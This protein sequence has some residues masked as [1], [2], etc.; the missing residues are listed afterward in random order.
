MSEEERTPALSI[1]AA[2]PALT[3]GP[4]GPAVMAGARQYEMIAKARELAELLAESE[5][6][7]E[8]AAAEEAMLGDPEAGR[9]LQAAEEAKGY[10]HFTAKT[11]DKALM[12]RAM[13]DFYKAE[14]MQRDYPP[15]HRYNE[16]KDRLQYLLDRLNAIITYPITGSDAVKS[17]GGG[18]GSGGSC[19][20][21]GT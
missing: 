14:A 3:A 11:Q 9:L 16:A 18:C 4:V 20:G 10:T 6:V 7:R 19:G 15:I 17:G 1:D 13:D 5:E 8:F 21:C 12:K 2:E